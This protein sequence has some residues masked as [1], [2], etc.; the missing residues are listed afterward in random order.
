MAEIILVIDYDE[1]RTSLEEVINS[2]ESQEGINSVE[3]K[4]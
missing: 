1:E 4:E 2:L 3:V